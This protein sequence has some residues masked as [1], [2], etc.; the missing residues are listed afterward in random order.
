M[1]ITATMGASQL[2][3]GAPDRQGLVSLLRGDVVQ[4]VASLLPDDIHLLIYA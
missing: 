3:L 4:N 1:D 2:V